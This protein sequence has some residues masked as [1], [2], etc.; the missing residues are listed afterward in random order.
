VT[1]ENAAHRAPL[2]G[3]FEKGFTCNVAVKI[4]LIHNDFMMFQEGG[5]ERHSKND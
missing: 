4:S 5:C 2:H 3:K 1:A